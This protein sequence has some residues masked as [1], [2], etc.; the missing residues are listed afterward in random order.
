M[1][2]KANIK[3]GDY[4]AGDI[5]PDEIAEKWNSMYE[6]S[7]VTQAS[8]S[9]SVSAPAQPAIAPK[10]EARIE[11]FKEDLLDDSKRNYSNRKKR[12]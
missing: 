11:D 5:V 1:V 6:K 2:W 3:I 4:K 12:R 10:V 9:S 8:D 7:P